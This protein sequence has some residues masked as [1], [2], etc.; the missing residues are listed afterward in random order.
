MKIKKNFQRKL[1]ISIARQKRKISLPSVSV[2]VPFHNEEKCLTKNFEGLISQTYPPSKIEII[3]VNDASTDNSLKTLHT[4]Q[5]KHCQ[6]L[7]KFFGFRIINLKRNKGVAHARNVGIQASRG[8]L[9]WLVDADC[10]P[11]KNCLS[12]LVSKL[13]AENADCVSGCFAQQP[14]YGDS[15]F[16]SKYRSGYPKSKLNSRPMPA[17]ACNNLYKRSIFNHLRFNEKY[18]GAGLEDAEFFERLLKKEFKICGNVGICGVDEARVFH[19]LEETTIS[20]FLLKRFKT[21]RSAAVFALRKKDY[22]RAFG[23]GQILPSLLLFPFIVYVL[24]IGNPLRLMFIVWILIN[25]FLFLF[26]VNPKISFF[27]SRNIKTT[28]TFIFFS[29]V[30][31]SVFLMGFTNQLIKSMI[32]R[33]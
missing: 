26:K 14:I 29:I 32:K 6:K 11:D 27:V 5:R 15:P 30:D 33:A 2:I 31:K 19:Q 9:I 20:D 13:L 24:R 25:F 12:L 16:L 21:G 28:L 23:L 17:P 10:W 22:L 7:K 18:P 8:E 3:Y 1:V 4:L